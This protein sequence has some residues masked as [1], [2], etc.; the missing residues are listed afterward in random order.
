MA[1]RQRLKPL[2]KTCGKNRTLE[3]VTQP[4]PVSPAALPKGLVEFDRHRPCDLLL[5]PRGHGQK[6]SRLRG[7]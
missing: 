1:L 5:D 6:T 3:F 2:A 7:P 4:S